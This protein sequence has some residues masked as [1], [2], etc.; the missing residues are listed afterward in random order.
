MKKYIISF[1][2]L[3]ISINAFAS[4]RIDAKVMQH[5]LVESCY[6]DT[7]ND[8]FG[9][10]FTLKLKNGHEIYFSDVKSDLTFGKWSRIFYINDVT[11]FTIDHYESSE[12]SG[13]Y[14]FLRLKDF[15]MT[16]NTEYYDVFAI[17]NNYKDFCKLLNTI[18]YIED[19]SAEKMGVKYSD[20]RY[21]YFYRWS[22]V[23]E[24]KLIEIPEE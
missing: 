21:V 16:T 15:C 3:I 22:K 8:C 4:G 18:P 1:F 17:L 19:A 10:A 14:R 20:K 5:P 2:I 13:Q 6:I 23:N 7:S 12:K 9:W 11:F 24:Y